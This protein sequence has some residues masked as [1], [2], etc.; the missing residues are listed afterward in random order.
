MGATESAMA[1][2]YFDTS[3]DNAFVDD[4]EGAEMTD[5]EAVQAEVSLALADMIR[6]SARTSAAGHVTV[7]VRDESG[8]VMSASLERKVVV[9]K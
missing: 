2:Y 5:M 6:E 9:F 8:L 3:I 1:R 7:S 4:P